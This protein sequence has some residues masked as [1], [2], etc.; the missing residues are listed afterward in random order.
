MGCGL[1]CGLGRSPQTEHTAVSGKR[2]SDKA[3]AFLAN[4]RV[5]DN[6]GTSLL[7]N[8]HPLD[9]LFRENAEFFAAVDQ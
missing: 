2:F 4:F 6:L 3:L 1:G 7:R 5:A 9:A 8:S